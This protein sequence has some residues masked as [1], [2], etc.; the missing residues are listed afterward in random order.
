VDATEP[1]A[2]RAADLYERIRAVPSQYEPVH[3]RGDS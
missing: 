1:S 3:A 2:E